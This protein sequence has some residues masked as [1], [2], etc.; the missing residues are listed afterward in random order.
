ME[1]EIRLEA[2]LEWLLRSLQLEETEQLITMPVK[3]AML[4]SKCSRVSKLFGTVESEN[5]FATVLTTITT[6]WRPDFSV[7]TIEIYTI[8]MT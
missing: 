3:L 1:L 5:M 6:I 2:C 8:I 7:A 4:L